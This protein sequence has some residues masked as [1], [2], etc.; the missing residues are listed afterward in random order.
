MFNLKSIYSQYVNMTQRKYAYLC[1]EYTDG[2][3]G[4]GERECTLELH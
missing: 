2:F 3:A 4:I 1:G